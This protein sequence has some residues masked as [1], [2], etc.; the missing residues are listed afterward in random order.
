M[1][2]LG[3]CTYSAIPRNVQQMSVF[4]QK[5]KSTFS[6]YC[7]NYHVITPPLPYFLDQLLTHVCFVY[8]LHG[9]EAVTSSVLDSPCTSSYFQWSMY[10]IT[11]R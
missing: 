7:L 3:H 11:N 4:D 9:C 2:S 5:N 1:V 10:S 6:Y 8:L